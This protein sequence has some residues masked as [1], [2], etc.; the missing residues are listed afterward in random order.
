[1]DIKSTQEK[2]GQR[3]NNYWKQYHT[4]LSDI[5]SK[6]NTTQMYGKIMLIGDF[7][8]GCRHQLGTEKEILYQFYMMTSPWCF[9][10]LN[11]TMTVSPYFTLIA[12]SVY[13]K[14]STLKHNSRNDNLEQ[15]SRQSI[16]FPDGEFITRLIVQRQCTLQQLTRARLLLHP[17]RYVPAAAKKRTYSQ[18]TFP[19]FPCY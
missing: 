9:I 10:A 7:M 12:P 8:L 16:I 6:C 2:Q 4:R 14:Q 1:M 17:L 13:T 15:F 3:K 5:F 18:N 11:W 19:P